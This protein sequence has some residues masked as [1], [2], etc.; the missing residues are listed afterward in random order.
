MVIRRSW[1]CMGSGIAL[2]SPTCYLTDRPVAYTSDVLGASN[3]A[4]KIAC[5][6]CHANE[7]ETDKYHCEGR[8]CLRQRGCRRFYPAADGLAMLR[9][10]CR[11]EITT[12]EDTFLCR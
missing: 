8:H 1:Y 3:S 9:V 2:S 4:A 6:T 12:K 5:L 7:S 11:L 10:I